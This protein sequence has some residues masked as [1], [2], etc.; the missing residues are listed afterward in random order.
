MER[1]QPSIQPRPILLLAAILMTIPVSSQAFEFQGLA[2]FTYDGGGEHMYGL[3][4]A[5]PVYAAKLKANQGKYI[6]VGASMM[7]D[8]RNFGVEATVGYKTEDYSGSVQKYSFDRTPVDVL[9]FFSLPT[10]EDGKSQIRF[11]IGPTVHIKPR[12]EESGTLADST[13]EFNTAVGIVAQIDTIIAFGRRGRS[14]LTLGIRYTNIDYEKSGGPSYRADGFG[15]FVG[16]RF[17]L[18]K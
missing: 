13:Y 6:A 17:P 1:K 10:G 14:G 4:V 18:G 15:F 7:N 16:G 5:A 12:V 9:G 11:G 3:P 2:K 8:A